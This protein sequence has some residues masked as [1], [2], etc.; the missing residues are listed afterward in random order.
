[1]TGRAILSKFRARDHDHADC[2]AAALANAAR[3]CA[4]RNAQLTP[5][6]RRVLEMI[7]ARHEPALAYDLLEQLRREKA[8]AAPPTVYRALRFLTELGLVHRIESLNAY[9]GC[10][11][12]AFKHSGQFLICSDCG[13]VAELDDPEIAALV[14]RKASAAGFRAQRQTIELTGLCPHCDAEASSHGR[15]G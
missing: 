6:R 13:R 11:D 5:I 14:R 10:G 8:R 3:V 7:W 12:P 9:V 4:A 15:R 1:M 2:L